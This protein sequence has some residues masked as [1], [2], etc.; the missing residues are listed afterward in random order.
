MKGMDSCQSPK[1]MDWWSQQLCR[2]AESTDVRPS[3][4]PC[5]VIACPA[6]QHRATRA[7]A[8]GPKA[9]TLWQGGDRHVNCWD[10]ATGP[11]L[12]RAHL[13]GQRL[14]SLA[15]TAPTI[16]GGGQDTAYSL[17][18]CTDH[19]ACAFDMRVSLH[20]GSAKPVLQWGAISPNVAPYVQMA[21]SKESGDGYTP[22]AL[23]RADGRLSLWDVRYTSSSQ[24]MTTPL[25]TLL[26]TPGRGIGVQALQGGTSWVVWGYEDPHSASSCC[27]K[28]ISRRS[29]SDGS[30]SAKNRNHRSESEV[31]EEALYAIQETWETPHLACVRVYDEHLVTL[32]TAES[33]PRWHCSVYR[34][35]HPRQRTTTGSSLTFVEPVAS[36]ASSPAATAPRG[37]IC[38]SQLALSTFGPTM[39]ETGLV[40]PLYAARTGGLLLVNMTQDGTVTTHVSEDFGHVRPSLSFFVCST[41]LTLQPFVDCPAFLPILVNS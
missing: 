2:G 30:A 17:L 6:D 31:D 7:L 24:S 40:P 18:A 22:V 3:S 35:S 9:A 8:F 21:A 13:P 26:V 32:Q 4:V 39:L 10:V 29:M 38:A 25:Q 23:L 41:L 14:V 34:Y 1:R 5:D 15:T 37:P 36:F 19:V 33:S 12:G 16:T 20:S 27:A 28:I 11:L